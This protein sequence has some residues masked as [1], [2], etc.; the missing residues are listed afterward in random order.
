M[1]IAAADPAAAYS[2]NLRMITL[3][4]ARC[5]SSLYLLSY[6]YCTCASCQSRKM[7]FN[8]LFKLATVQGVAFF[9][10]SVLQAEREMEGWNCCC[11]SMSACK[12]KLLGQGQRHCSCGSQTEVT[13]HTF[14]PTPSFHVALYYYYYY[15]F[16]C[17]SLATLVS[18]PSPCNAMQMQA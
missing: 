1:A 8:S 18:A 12:H 17:R 11:N 6:S 4:C 14:T 10:S 13:H 16:C 15:Y 2:N 7:L 5:S 9:S 3:W